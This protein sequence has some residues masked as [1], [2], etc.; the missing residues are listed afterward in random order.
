MKNVKKLL[1]NTAALT[2]TALAMKTVAVLYNVF[3]TEKIGSAGIG[4]FT[5]V[6]T[7]YAFIKTLGSSGLGL[8]GTRLSIDEKEKT[9]YHMRRLAFVGAL[10]GCFAG[11]V[12]FFGAE[13]FSAIWIGN[14]ETASALRILSASLPFVAV[15]ACFGGYFTAVRKMALFAGITFSEQLIK[16]FFTVIFINAA[17]TVHDAINGIAAA[18]V[19][20]EAYS[21]SVS[22]CAYLFYGRERKAL[23]K[24]GGFRKSFSRIAVPEAVGA[25]IRSALR[26]AEHLLIPVGLKRSGVSETEALASYG[27]IQGLALPVLLY[28]SSLLTSL[29]GLLVPEIAESKANGSE[30]HV[31]Y[32]IGRVLSCALIFSM[33]VFSVMYVFPDHLSAAIYGTDEAE[34][35]IKILAPL[36]PVM[37]LDMTVDGMLKGLDKQMSVMRINILDS[38]F[39]V[40]LVIFLVPAK[41][42]DGYIITI[43]LAECGNFLLSFRRLYKTVPAKIDV[44]PKV[45]KPL[46][47]SAASAALSR[48]ALS[49]A[50]LPCAWLLFFEISL[51]VVLYA[52]LISLFKCFT[53]EEKKWLFGIIGID[54]RRD[55]T[56]YSKK[57]QNVRT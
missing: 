34:R 40:L 8:A 18:I 51:S 56:E 20:S 24:K 29:S 12:L 25:W 5:L 37:Y 55:K 45:I 43:F 48:V 32:I 11:A 17:P 54:K 15:T 21:F 35:F 23:R 31:R 30:K 39:C 7:V 19:I 33:C 2:A 38:L 57:D 4:L 53:T 13:A 28:P 46:I 14:A 6:M 42:V 49:G 44:I 47:A 22:L 50:E 26:T 3:L 16:I 10:L 9:V 36:I 27:A 41:A 52:V 1:L